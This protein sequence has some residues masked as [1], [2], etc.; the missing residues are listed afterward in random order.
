MEP[1]NQLFKNSKHSDGTSLLKSILHKYIAIIIFLILW[2]IFPIIGIFNPLF[3]PPPS[4]VFL[5]MGKLIIDGTLI[6]ATLYTFMRV[7]LGITMAILI[8]IPLGFLLGGFF[9]KFEESINPVIKIIEQF[10]P[11]TLFHLFIIFVALTDFSTVMVVYWA[12][13]WPILNNTVTGSKNVDISLIKV[14]KAS[15]LDKFD[16]F[17]KIQVPASIPTILGGIRLGVI[18]ALLIVMGVEMMG[19]NTSTGLGY[20]IMTTQMYG[21]TSEMWAGI[22]TMT[23]LGI[24]INLGLLKIE[25]Y[26]SPWKKRSY[27]Q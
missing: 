3:I 7:I 26:L 2:E 4:V 16:I 25:K 18:F 14:G 27:I 5:T 19:M 8:A 11:L 12:A 10:N 21:L 23:L 22:V 1:K 15:N 6:V 24:V 9:K 13:Q 17:W 20:F